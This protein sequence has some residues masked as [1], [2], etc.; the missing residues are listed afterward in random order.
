LATVPGITGASRSLEFTGKKSNAYQ[1]EL[2]D[3]SR[4]RK[5]GIHFAG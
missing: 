5:L 4:N 2:P 3:K 1:P